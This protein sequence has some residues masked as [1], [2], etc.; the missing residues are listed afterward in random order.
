MTDEN[1]PREDTSAGG[2]KNRNMRALEAVEG[3]KENKCVSITH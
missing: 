1:S 2:D 3:V